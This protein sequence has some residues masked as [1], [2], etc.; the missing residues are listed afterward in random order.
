VELTL[1][2]S[3]CTFWHKR[4]ALCFPTHVTFRVKPVTLTKLCILDKGRFI[5]NKYTFILD[6][7]AT[8]HIVSKKE[9]FHTYKAIDKLIH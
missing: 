5:N 4:R 6:S 2:N 3:T 1:V 9:H 7:A 8:S